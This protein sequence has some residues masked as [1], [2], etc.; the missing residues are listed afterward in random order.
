[1]ILTDG[2]ASAPIEFAVEDLFRK[3]EFQFVLRDCHDNFTSNCLPL[4]IC[5]GVIFTVSVMPVVDH[6][7]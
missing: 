7:L 1:M 6:R 3:I 2:L 5:C 4:Q